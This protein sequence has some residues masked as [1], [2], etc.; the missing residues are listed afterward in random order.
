M[1]KVERM[2]EA[3]MFKTQEASHSHV[4]LAK[5]YLVGGGEEIFGFI[6]VRNETLRP[7]CL[8]DRSA[9]LSR[10]DAPN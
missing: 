2:K 10:F 7:G 1:N 8:F 4:I 5:S 6:Y 3:S 9:L